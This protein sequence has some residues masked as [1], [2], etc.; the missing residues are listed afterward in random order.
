MK[1]TKKRN[2]LFLGYKVTELEKNAI[3][4][5]PNTHDEAWHVAHGTVLHAK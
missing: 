3:G 4:K 5:N 2:A 1:A